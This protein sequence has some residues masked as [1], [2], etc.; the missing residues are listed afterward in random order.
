MQK[1]IDC[2]MLGL[3]NRSLGTID[4]AGI[5][6]RN[7]GTSPVIGKKYVHYESPICHQGLVEIKADSVKDG[8]EQACNLPANEC[9]SFV[10]YQPGILPQDNYMMSLAEA[11]EEARVAR[12]DAKEKVRVARED[13]KEEVRRS[14]VRFKFWTR[15][16][17]VVIGILISIIS[18][19]FNNNFSATH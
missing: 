18:I 11:R 19:L 5:A 15:T 6:Y 1:C 4:E 12:E 3:V 13:A 16:L 2:G 7:N 17:L 9:P 14:E 8:Y 10:K